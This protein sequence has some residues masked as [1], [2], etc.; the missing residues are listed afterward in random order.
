MMA[1]IA[2]PDDDQIQSRVVFVPMPY[3]VDFTGFLSNTVAPKWLERL[4]MQ[5]IHDHFADQDLFDQVNLSVIARSEIDY[6]RPIRMGACLL[7]HAW[8]EKCMRSSWT[9]RFRLRDAST[10][11]V[12]LQARQVGAFIDP[13]TLTPMRVPQAV[14]ARVGRAKNLTENRHATRNA[15]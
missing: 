6:L 10:R 9:I 15:G 2:N 13:N 12:C 3:E 4:R 1:R 7:G 14:R 5:L 11:E 8:I